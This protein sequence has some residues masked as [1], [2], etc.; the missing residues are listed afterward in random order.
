MYNK[1]TN[2]RLRNKTPKTKRSILKGIKTKRIRTKRIR[3]KRI[4]TKR[5]G[6]N[7]KG[8]IYGI[9]AR[10]SGAVH[11]GTEI[12]HYH[13]YVLLPDG[14]NINLDTA[15]GITHFL[16]EQNDQFFSDYVANILQTIEDK[17]RDSN[18]TL[19]W[20]GKML[21]PSMKLRRINTDGNFINLSDLS[22]D[23][24][25][26]AKYT[27]QLTRED[28]ENIADEY[29][30]EEGSTEY[31]DKP[32]TPREQKGEHASKY[33][34]QLITKFNEKLEERKRELGI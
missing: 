7:K 26:T 14:R 29:S 12:P 10:P 18:L 1:Y 3:T 31:R 32:D 19:F 11:R 20:R 16:E 4:R 27:N 28:F 25:L 30:P 2:K 24:N 13:F 15:F 23:M 21:L 22:G 34:E 9:R 6:K 17:T 5:Y 33:D 8:G